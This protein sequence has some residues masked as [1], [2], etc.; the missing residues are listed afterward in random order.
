MHLAVHKQRATNKNEYPAHSVGVCVCTL[1][2]QQTKSA[3]PDIAKVS[4][5]IISF[6]LIINR[7]AVCGHK[8]VFFLLRIFLFRCFSVRIHNLVACAFYSVHKHG[9]FQVCTQN[10]TTPSV[11]VFC[12]Y[13]YIYLLPTSTYVFY[14]HRRPNILKQQARMY[15]VHICVCIMYSLVCLPMIPM[16]I[17]A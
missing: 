17:F 16:V 10:H 11:H 8:I 2:T 7:L 14:T 6:N 3:R 9:T 13:L 4:S 5:L 15:C 1:Y 12:Q